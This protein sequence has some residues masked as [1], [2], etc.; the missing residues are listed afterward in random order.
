MNINVHV[1]NWNWNLG[2]RIFGS[3]PGD[4]AVIIV[5]KKLKEF[6]I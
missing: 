3:M 1:K 2:I 4:K 6:G 5:R